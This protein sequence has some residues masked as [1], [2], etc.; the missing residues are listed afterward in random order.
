MKYTFKTNINCG[1]CI[2]KVQPV[3]DEIKGIDSWEVDTQ[4]PDKILTVKSEELSEAQIQEVVIGA[5]FSAEPIKQ[6]FW[7]KIW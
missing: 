6:G 4:N 3:L 7:K 2:A 5:G 1:G